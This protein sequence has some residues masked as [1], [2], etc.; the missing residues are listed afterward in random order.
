MRLKKVFDIGMNLIRSCQIEL[1][2]RKKK[3]KKE[4]ENIKK[5]LTLSAS[6]KR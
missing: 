4:E 3:Y 2:N 5:H 6:D 1:F